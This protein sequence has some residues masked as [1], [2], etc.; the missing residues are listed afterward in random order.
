MTTAVVLPDAPEDIAGQRLFAVDDI[1]FTV[2]DVARRARPGDRELLAAGDDPADVQE[3]FRRARGLLTA[4]RLTD[5][6]ADW[7]ITPDEFQAWSQAPSGSGSW[8]ALVCS[9][10]LDRAAAEVAA[11]A[12][13]A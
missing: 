10:A 2:A 13:A 12:A 7:S 4:D 11:A 6:L 9:G 8:A 5:W 1:E 3:S